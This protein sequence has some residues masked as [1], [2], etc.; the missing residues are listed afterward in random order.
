[1]LYYR[2]ISV[3]LIIAP[4][5]V[6]TTHGFSV[7][8]ETAFYE[9]KTVKVVEGR[10]PGGL[11]SFRTQ[12]VTKYLE[13]H[14]AGNPA[15]VFQYMPGGGGTAAS[16][17]IANVAKRDGLTIGN[18]GSAVYSDALFGGAG[19]RYNLDDFVF[20]G[21]PSPINPT[22]LIVR[23]GLQLDTVEKLK[24]YR[25][26]RFANRSVGHGLYVVDRVYAFVLELQEPRWILGYS[27]PEVNVALERGE[28]DAK[29]TNLFS[30]MRRNPQW[31]K[32]GFGF[33]IVMKGSIGQGAE[34][35]PSF[36]QDRPTLDQYADTKLKKAVIDLN[37]ASRPS[38]A[39]F[40][41]H[42]AVP[43][44]V[45]RSLKEAFGKMWRDP[46]FPKEYYRVVAEPLM[47]VTGP[48]IEEALRKMPRDPKVMEVYKQLIS[49]GP[50][51]SAR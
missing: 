35:V 51:P 28:A 48:E 1:M 32:Q 25:G 20:L 21:A 22:T 5:L 30:L 29:T 12:T 24:A 45:L 3:G 39:V 27:S 36:P 4:L 44:E 49:A 7:S 2:L 14:L 31:L 18:V 47:P 6:M 42:K 38:S 50:L 8:A 9:G 33:P 16:N 26:L 40:F 37:H 46:E 15:F 19:V 43:K 34:V 41:V 10:A 11:G 17:H 23:P 13:K